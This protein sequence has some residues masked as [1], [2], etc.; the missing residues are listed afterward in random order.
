MNPWVKRLVVPL[1]VAAV[2]CL[3]VFDSFTLAYL[4]RFKWQIAFSYAE[5]ASPEAYLKA[6][7]VVAYFW[8]LLFQGGGLYD[9]SKRRS[10]IDT[11]YAI[12]KAI[13]YGTL[14]IL[15][16]TYFYREVSFSRLACVYAWFISLVLFGTFRISMNRLR[17]DYH[18]RG[19]STRGV[20]VVGGRSLAAFLVEKIGA[21][22]E[23]GYR[24]VGALD[25]QEPTMNLGCDILGRV[26]DLEAVLRAQDVGRV[27]IAHPVLSHTQ[28]LEVIDTCERLDVKLAMVPPTYDLM[29]NHR[30]FE[31]VDGVP[32]VS[33]NEKEVRRLRDV[34]K[35][36]FDIVSASV[37][38]ALFFPLWLLAA[39]LI[40]LEDG[41]EVIFSQQRVGKDGRVFSMLK[42]R[43]MVANAEA[44]LPELVDL[45]ELSQPV[46]K[47]DNDPRIT[48]AGRFLRRTSLDELPQ[49][50]NVICGHMSLVG[51]RPEEEKVVTR[52]DVWQRRRLKAMPG[53]TGLQQVECRGS[54]DLRERVR[55]D[56]L[57]LRK[58]TLFLDLWIVMKTAWVVLLGKGAR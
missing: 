36:V 31:E 45:D 44:L 47:L 2:D 3:I 35:R 26:E 15:S 28:L 55:W 32:L 17:D 37:L 19:A 34:T 21:R 9:F 48:R 8:I 25:D 12:V 50:L 14:I 38:M 4:L 16:I 54:T 43:T 56:V 41:G 20:L 18:R 40:K 10:N 51:P 53:I 33:V 24:V 11:V 23:L 57:Y 7:A 5:P 49:L 58:Q 29:I 22:P 46:F 13:T 52:Y 30:D 27:F 42:F 39:L 1:F 6:M